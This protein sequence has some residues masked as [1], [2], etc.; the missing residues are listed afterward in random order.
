VPL[1]RDWSAQVDSLVGYLRDNHVFPEVAD[2]VCG[3]LRQRLADGAYRRLT[4]DVDFAS[5]VTTDL[6]SVN[7]D[8]HLRLRYRAAQMPDGADLSSHD[9]D[10]MRQEAE[11]TEHG[12]AKVARLPG[13]VGL[14]DI[15]AMRDAETSGFAAVAAM[16]L[17][18]GAD[19]LI[20]DLH[21][22]G[23]GDPAMVALW[24]S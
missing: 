18:A 20:V 11:L 1:G 23:G 19:V 14:L 21:A 24:S 9:V 16:N 8:Q 4:E 6:Q 22:N 15:R 13:N 12:F 7:G 17:M 10:R 3:L 2:Q 5:A